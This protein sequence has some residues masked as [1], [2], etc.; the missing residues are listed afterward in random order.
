MHLPPATKPAKHF[1]YC[2]SFFGINVFKACLNKV[3]GQSRAA[4]KHHAM[5]EGPRQRRAGS[6]RGV[7]KMYALE[8]L[9]DGKQNHR[10]PKQSGS[11]IKTTKNAL[12]W[13]NRFQ[14]TIQTTKAT[15]KETRH[16]GSIFIM[17]SKTI[18]RNRLGIV[19][20]SLPPWWADL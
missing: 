3:V 1:G 11:L 14:I 10:T 9:A 16:W 17:V 6:V 18:M 15:G 8:K 20:I 5:P 13:K 7:V 19:S 12:K 2:H 4:T